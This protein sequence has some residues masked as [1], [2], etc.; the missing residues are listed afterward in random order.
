MKRVLLVAVVFSFV[1]G[2]AA[3][4][5]AELPKQVDKFAKGTM[6][7][8]KSPLVIYDHTKSSIDTADYKAVGL[9]KGLLESPFHVVKKAGK[10]ALD[11]AT[12]LID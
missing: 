11:M 9:F 1:V 4:A 12:F 7:V 5:F 2:V 8:I 10:G 3:S 6:D